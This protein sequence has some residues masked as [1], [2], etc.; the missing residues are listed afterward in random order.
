MTTPNLATTLEQMN[1]WAVKTASFASMHHL[2]KTVSLAQLQFEIDAVRSLIYGATEIS[3]T[4]TKIVCQ[5]LLVTFDEM[6]GLVD[7]FAQANHQTQF[8]QRI[9]NY[10]K[11]FLRLK[12]VAKLVLRFKDEDLFTAQKVDYEAA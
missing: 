7:D 4:T 12:A 9:D 6:M 2:S 3:P 8:Y 11:E 1:E 10:R 5:G